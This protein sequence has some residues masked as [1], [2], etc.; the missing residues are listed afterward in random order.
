MD[1]LAPTLEQY[2]ALAKDSPAFQDEPDR[3]MEVT[4]LGRVLW[5]RRRWIVVSALLLVSLAVAYSLLTPSEFT[6]TGQIFIDPRDRQVLKDDV[7][8]GGVAADG[9]IGLV[10]SQTKVLESTNVLT[11]VVQKLGL[12]QDPE[13]DGQ[14]DSKLVSTIAGWLGIDK[15][16][17]SDDEK[18]SL[19]LR[20]IRKRLTVQRADKV[21]VVTVSFASKDPDKASRVVNAILES[22]LADQAEARTDSASKAANALSAGLEKQR[23]KV[24]DAENALERYKAQHG[25][26]QANDVLV[27]DQ[28][29]LDL[30]AKLQAAKASTALLQTRLKNAENSSG[31]EASTAE[32]MTSSTISQLRSQEATLVQ[33]LSSL[34]DKY[35]PK[36]PT[37]RNVAIQLKNIDALIGKELARL[38]ASSANDYD[39]ALKYE[40]SLQQAYDEAK[41]KKVES[42][43][44]LIRLRQ[45]ENDL[46]LNRTVYLSFAKR[47]QETSEQAGIDTTNARIISWASAPLE[48]SWPK[49]GLLV[50]VAAA[51]GLGLG[52]FAAFVA[53]YASP[54]I[55]SPGDM[56][57]LTGAADLGALGLAPEKRSLIKLPRSG[58]ASRLSSGS[59]LVIARTLLL[60]DRET[61]TRG[62]SILITS[63][64]Q[65]ARERSEIL[66]S[67]AMVALRLSRKV[68]YVD[69]RSAQ[70]AGL[71]STGL[72]EV[73]RG[74]QS[75]A[76]AMLIDPE[77]GL[78][79][80]TRG[81]DAVQRRG[82]AASSTHLRDVLDEALKR[83]DLVILDGSAIADDLDILPIA[84]AVD[85]V[86]FVARAG[87]TKRKEVMRANEVLRAVGRRISGSMLVTAPVLN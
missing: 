81:R 79:I 77:T 29:L 78:S 43:E 59:E 15:A 63:G 85:E 23:E 5:R 8:P 38:K 1:N 7:N 75:L 84:A 70:L 22:Y 87:E 17:K 31:S 46:D 32:A 21:F 10:E 74:E 60:F 26:M 40:R 34:R 16:V 83:F 67:F 45:L 57:R 80:M 72:L 58:G 2:P 44:T 50:A 49:T 82:Y 30:A 71:P 52:A 3:M 27:T 39:R 76:S 33:Q 19:V 41:G 86:I 69:G 73:A 47:A 61:A 20:E 64:R 12:E 66:M 25:V 6:A 4:D 28:E 53:E 62:R 24:R 68:L 35:G 14:S 13:L 37:L 54:T 11:R 51:T 48:K 36:H 9:G 18:M 56:K 42:D 55:L 65:E